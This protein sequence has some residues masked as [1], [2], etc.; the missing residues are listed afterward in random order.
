MTGIDYLNG[1][2]LKGELWNPV[3]GCSGKGCK[4]RDNCWARNIVKR[5]PSHHDGDVLKPSPLIGKRIDFSQP[6]FHPSRLDKPLHWKKRRRIGVCFMGDLFDE[7]V[8]FDW[9]DQIVHIM[10]DTKH[11]YFVLTKQPQNLLRWYKQTNAIGGGDWTHNIYWGI[12]IT[13]QADLDRMGPILLQIPGKHWISYEPAR[14]TVDFTEICPYDNPDCKCNGD[15]NCSQRGLNILTG[16]S[17]YYDEESGE[18]YSHWGSSLNWLT[19]GA[20]SGP[21]RHP[22]PLEWAYDAVE[23]CKAAG[24]PVWVKQLTIN[25]KVCHNIEQFPKQLQRREYPDGI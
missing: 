9:I 5:F 16:E 12:S 17:K 8:S 6:I 23:Q 24:V 19:I 22:M 13:D 7:Q 18:P 25:N 21:K 14:G 3:S 15:M 10:Q 2:G 1:N 20:E 11:T 4:V